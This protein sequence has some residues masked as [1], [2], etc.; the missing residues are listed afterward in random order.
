MGKDQK[1]FGG[2]VADHSLKNQ[3]V[4]FL[5]L[6]FFYPVINLKNFSVDAMRL[7]RLPK[8]EKCYGQA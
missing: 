1:H 6:R 5:K 7:H 8:Y 2:C 3:R 4:M